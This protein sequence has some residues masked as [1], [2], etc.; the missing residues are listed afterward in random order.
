MKNDVMLPEPL[1]NGYEFGPA[2]LK[3]DGQTAANYMPVVTQVRKYVSGEKVEVYVTISVTFADGTM[4]TEI[5]CPLCDIDGFDAQSDLDHRCYD[6]SRK[7][8]RLVQNLIRY[9]AAQKSAVEVYRADT[10]GFLHYGDKVAYNAGSRLLGD[11]GVEVELVTSG[12]TFSPPNNV[13]NEQLGAYIKSIIQLNPS[14]SA[15]IFAYFILGILRDLYR[16]A[17]VPIHFCMFLFGQQQSLKTT[18]AT[19]LCSL[20]DRHE[21]VERHLHNL[22]AT[23]IKL[24]EILNI[25]KDSV[26]IIDDLNL[27]DSKRKEREQEAKISGLIRA[28]ANGVGRETMRD[29]KS[30]N[31]QPLFCGEY[32]LKNTSTNNRLLILHL[33]QGQ[34]NMQKLYE[35]QQDANLLTAFA[36][37]LIV[38]V[39]DNYQELC[40]FIANQYRAFM[41]VRAG[42]IFYQERLNRSGAVMAIAYGVFLRFCKVKGWDVGLTANG[43]NDIIT[44]ILEQQIE[45]L[46]LQGKDEPDHIVELYRL[47][48]SE[49]YLGTVLEG[50]PKGYVWKS[51]IYYDE[52]EDYVY[53]RNDK[54]EE[55]RQD[56]SQKFKR[57]VSIHEL[58][59][60][61]DREGIIV[62]DSDNKDAN[63][64][65]PRSKIKARH[66]CYVI[67]YDRL[68]QYAQEIAEEFED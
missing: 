45:Y 46:N 17:G 64:H 61:L 53:I 13:S 8:R 50:H 25:E 33:E 28:A 11:L 29:Q 15:P 35:I 24:H 39:L 55:M 30:I 19:Y 65:R 2:G 16:H 59:D 27:D 31:A 52:R 14:V 49:Q 21:D 6:Y 34:I 36:Q 41:E 32:L 67:R 5:S 22:T 38:W 7:S 23:E 60:A 3:V 68:E 51:T 47:F 48:R 63:E 12:Y 20:Y 26:A 10:L 58:L 43:F 57:H 44:A 4:S 62:K 56:I 9:F 42:G 1:P 40:Q 54:M 66:R 37:Q 18:L